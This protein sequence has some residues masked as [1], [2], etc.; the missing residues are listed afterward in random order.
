ML[1]KGTSAAA[2]ISRSLHRDRELVRTQ[3]HIF[4]LSIPVI[5]AVH[6]WCMGGGTWLALS[7]DITLASADAVFAQPE[8]RQISNSSFLWTLLAGHKNALRYA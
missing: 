3:T 7:C 6:G 4:E 5:A 1:P 8:V 2:Y